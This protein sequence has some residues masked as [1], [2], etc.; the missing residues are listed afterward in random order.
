MTAEAVRLEKRPDVFLEEVSALRHL[1]GVIGRNGLGILRGDSAKPNERDQR[2]KGDNTGKER[3]YWTSTRGG[4]D[5]LAY[6]RR[7]AA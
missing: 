1:R 6:S 2:H 3:H 7:L 4:G 5:D